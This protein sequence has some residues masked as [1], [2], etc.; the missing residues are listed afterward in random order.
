MPRSQTKRRRRRSRTETVL[1][2]I[3]PNAGIRSSYAKRLTDLVTEMSD[4]IIYWMSAA[5]R[6]NPP[7]MA[8]DEPLIRIEAREVVAAGGA[9]R[10]AAMVDG[11]FLVSETTGRTRMF[12]SAEAARRAGRIA[13]GQYVPAD[14]L[15]AA[16]NDLAEEWQDQFD[17]AAERI[18]AMFAQG[19]ARHSD[20]ALVS[21]LKR[22]GFAVSFTMTPAMRDVLASTVA[23]NVAL[24]RS[25]PQ[26]YLTNV[27]GAVMRSV[28]QGRDLGS[29]TRYLRHQHGV[30]K[31]RAAFISLDQNN[32][33]T[34]ALQKARQVELGIEEAI[35]M[36]SH[37]GREPRPTHVAND[38]KR[39]NVAEGW[40]DPD[41][42]VRRRIW[43]GELPRCRCT[44][45]AVM[46]F[47]VEAE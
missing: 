38:G 15:N 36:H 42:R 45:R 43:P 6:A 33:A 37:A 14:E 31:R 10:W 47:K 46:P 34:S 3:R 27:Q 18:A 8:S 9:T 1:R 24:I 17:A 16:F 23:Q 32:K 25:V 21:V 26:Q 41:P 5:Y 30:A 19:A 29:L 4:S 40:Y 44:Q 13:L 12:R 7:V 2:P 11:E 39:Y 22:S 20:R 28:Q 35:W